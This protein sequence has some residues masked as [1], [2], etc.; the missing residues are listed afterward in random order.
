MKLNISFSKLEKLVRDIVASPITWRS[1]ANRLDEL[2]IEAFLLEG[3]E[4]H[5]LN[6][7]DVTEEGLLTY[8]GKGVL[9]YIKDTGISRETNENFPEKSRRFHFSDCETLE[10]MREKGKF[11]RYII[12][13]NQSGFFK[14]DYH[15]KETGEHGETQARLRVCKNCLK[16]INYN[17]YLKNKEMVFNNLSIKDFFEKHHSNF[18]QKPKYTDKDAPPSRYTSDWDKISRKEKQL[19]N[20]TCKKCKVNLSAHPHC[21]HTHHKNSVK[22]DNSQANLE[23]LCQLCHAEHHHHMKP[24]SR[25]TDTIRQLRKEQ[26]LP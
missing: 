14:V 10:E 5:D 2:N 25:V 15:E 11:E 4:T 7:V 19:S 3:I 20:W 17:N 8:K 23:V 22:Y 18:K 24:Y 21:L 13:M 1:D 26:G 9:L 12:T 6:D 16:K